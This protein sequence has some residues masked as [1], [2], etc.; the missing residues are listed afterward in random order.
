MSV[1]ASQI[2]SLTI[3]TTVYS[4]AGQRKHQ[5]S[6]SLA[7]VRGFHWWPVNKGPVTRKSFHL[8]TPCREEL[9][10]W[11]EMT[12]LIVYQVQVALRRHKNHCHGMLWL[13]PKGSRCLF[14]CYMS[15]YCSTVIH[16]ECHPG[17]EL[18][19]HRSRN[20]LFFFLWHNDVIKWKHFPRY[21][22]FVWGIRRSS[23]KCPHKCQRRGALMFSLICA[24]NKRLSKQSWVWWF[25]TLSRWLWSH[26][27]GPRERQGKMGYCAALSSLIGSIFPW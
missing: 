3:V 6:A 10:L 24:L 21:W 11:K 17:V 18:G 14:N 7:F 5:S 19:I 22:P 23:V 2:T 25:E 26:C 27:N 8:M 12:C 1:M 13:Y 4:G 9:D 20:S 15:L 16:I